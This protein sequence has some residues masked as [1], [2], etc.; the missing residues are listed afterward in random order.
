MAACIAWAVAHGG[1]KSD[2]TSYSCGSDQIVCSDN[3]GSKVPCDCWEYAGGNKGHVDDSA[4]PSC[5]CPS[6]SGWPTWN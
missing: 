4:N 6:G 5:G 3:T 2:C 1:T